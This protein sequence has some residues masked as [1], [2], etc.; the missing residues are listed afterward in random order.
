MK[1]LIM[2]Q[3][4]WK[5]ESLFNNIYNIIEKVKDDE[6]RK[7]KRITVKKGITYHTWSK[8]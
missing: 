5:L 6:I 3:G 1:T 7:L 2:K 8:D 4:E